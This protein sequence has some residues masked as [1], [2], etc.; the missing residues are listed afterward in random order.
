VHRGWSADFPATG[1]SRRREPVCRFSSKVADVA[2]AAQMPEPGAQE[3]PWVVRL[4]HTMLVAT[5]I[6]E[7]LHQQGGLRPDGTLCVTSIVRFAI[8]AG[9]RTQGQVP[10]YSGPWN[11]TG[12]ANSVRSYITALSSGRESWV[13]A[14]NGQVLR[15]TAGSSGASLRQEH[16]RDSDIACMGLDG[17][18]LV[19]A[20]RRAD[21]GFRCHVGQ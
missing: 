18:P 1:P 14:A 17:T 9:E 16:G 11:D 2:P 19:G 10:D 13:V 8:L 6:F 15:K 7:R 4:R 3:P 5:L 20:P 21:S 12:C